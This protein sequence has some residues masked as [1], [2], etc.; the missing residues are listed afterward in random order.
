MRVKTAD[1]SEKRKRS[2]ARCCMRS[3]AANC[4]CGRYC[5]YTGYAVL[6][7]LRYDLTFPCAGAYAQS[8]TFSHHHRRTAR[9][10]VRT[11]SARVG[12]P[13]VRDLFELLEAVSTATLSWW[14]SKTLP[15]R[16]LH[17]SAYLSLPHK[18]RTSDASFGAIYLQA[19]HTCLIAAIWQQTSGA[20][21]L[22][23]LLSF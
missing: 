4:V 3:H 8:P 23:L 10:R 12:L 14:S 13:V 1:N 21:W 11:S 2:S 7:A 5:F 22:H 19:S 15:S 17:E 16:L 20:M 6:T 18:V 9:H